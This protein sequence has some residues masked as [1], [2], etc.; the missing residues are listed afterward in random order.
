MHI[1]PVELLP[2]EQLL[3]NPDNPKLPLGQRFDAGLEAS[4]DEFGFAG[5]LAVASNADGTYT[6]LDG[7]TRLDKLTADGVEQVPCVAIPACAE[8]ADGWREA[9]VKFTL[10]HDRNRKIFDEEAVLRQ[11]K[12]LAGK[13]QNVKAL[14][15]LTAVP[16][17]P[18]LLEESSRQAT[19]AA[20]AL[21]KMAPAAQ[22]SLVLYGPKEDVDAVRQLVK[23]V[24][25]RFSDIFKLRFSMEQAEH[26][27]DLTDEQFLLGFASALARMQHDE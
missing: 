10:A 20:A 21:P 11:L 18:R 23:R 19:K 25:G 16:N 24:R 17:L 5:V 4:L 12:D 1:N 3:P 6:V 14:A 7:T 9:R 26:N 2:L 15:K 8:G 27:L 13:G 22:A